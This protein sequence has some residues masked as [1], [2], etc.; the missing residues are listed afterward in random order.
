MPRRAKGA[1]LYL[2]QRAGREAVWIIRDGAYERGTGCSQDCLR[3]AEVE[4]ANYVLSKTTRAAIESARRKSDPAQVGLAEVIALYLDERAPKRQTDTATTAGFFAHLLAWWGDKTVAD[5]KRSTCQAYVAHRMTMP[6]ARY[7]DPA[8]APRVSD[9]TAARELDD[10]SA[11]IGY[12]SGEDALSNRPK[13]TKPPKPESS[14][15]AL[16]RS[17]AAALLK[18][19]LG[20]RRKP[21]GHWERLSS[22]ARANRAHLRRFILIGLYTGTRHS[23]MRALLWEEALMQ[24]WV[25]LDKGMVYRR[26]KGERET[27]K[28]RPVVKLPKRL[29]AHMR[30]W[31]RIDG[32]RLALWREQNPNVNVVP[33]TTVLHHGGEPIAGKIRTGFEGCVRDA[34]LPSN[35]TPH[36]MRHTAA[37]WLME[38]GC[39]MWEAAGYLGM[40]VAILEKHYGHHRPDHQSGAVKAIGGKR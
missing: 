1:R 26:G 11:A 36:W 2:K 40:S 27:T 31:R 20:Y 21:D 35:I 9:Q 30:R 17:Q 32:D 4:L 34:G 7:K 8:T 33:F 16:T 15:D 37:T 29:L 22:S 12:W 10:L 13:I 39:D 6:H 19:S 38:N 5:V 24:A 18:A 3:E 28:R 23:A 25:D 14:R